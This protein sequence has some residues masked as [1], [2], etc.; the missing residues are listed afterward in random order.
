MLLSHNRLRPWLGLATVALCLLAARET[1]AASPGG[2]Q[3]ALKRLQSDDILLSDD[4]VEEIVEFGAPAVDLL[5]PLLEDPRRDVKAGSIRALGLLGDA[6]AR[7]PLRAQLE[8]SLDPSRP[9]DLSRRYHRIL[10]IQSLGRLGD[11][12]SA[13]M[14]RDILHSPDPFERAHAAISL[15]LFDADPGYDAVRE[16]LQDSDPA[17]R[18]VAVVG[19]GES[20]SDAARDLLLSAA[21]DESWVVRDSA[22]RALA[23]HSDVAEV[24]EAYRQGANDPSW[25]VRE[26]V[27]ERAPE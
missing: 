2:L 24:Q 3:G 27:A 20:P 23:R 13:P 25:Y 12:E 4:A 26:T 11:T 8:E 14:L 19:L 6:R 16:S 21:H 5:L 10:L 22:F 18:N 1:G 7:E 15:F 17:V 9:D